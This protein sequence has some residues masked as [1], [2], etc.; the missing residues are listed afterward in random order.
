MGY[1][2]YWWQRTHRSSGAGFTLI[3]VLAVTAVLL[4]VGSIGFSSMT[5]AWNEHLL[6]A[7]SR[8]AHSL[9]QA[10]RAHA[11]MRSRSVRIEFVNAQAPATPYIAIFD[12]TSPDPI[13]D[14]RPQHLPL[15]FQLLTVHATSKSVTYNSWGEASWLPSTGLTFRVIIRAPNGQERHLF[16][17]RA[18]RIMLVKP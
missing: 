12:P 14:F 17:H 1:K 15:G 13:A 18:G 5:S 16:F 2:E 3:E 9:V 11:V 10:A 6:I 8:Q 7:Q 4:M